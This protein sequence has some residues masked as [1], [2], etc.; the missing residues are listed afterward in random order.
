MRLYLTV[1]VPDHRKALSGLLLADHNLAE[2]RLRYQER[3]QP[4]VPREWRLC[5][6]C[7]DGIEEPLHALFLCTNSPT[8]VNLRAA[9]FDNCGIDPSNLQHL[10]PLGI[11]H[12]MILD[13]KLV[14]K[15]AK[16]CYLV[17]QLYDT[18]PMLVPARE[19]FSEVPNETADRRLHSLDVML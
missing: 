10:T 19:W 15:F 17:L 2:V 3:H 4:P 18:F 12:Q 5:R 11:L 6:L 7:G 1:H 9:F 14:S 13:E 16:F 8:L